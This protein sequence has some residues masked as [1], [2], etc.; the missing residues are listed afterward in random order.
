MARTTTPA[1]DGLRR[2][3]LLGAAAGTASALA[4][5]SGG[6]ARAVT[7][8]AEEICV[9]APT[10]PFDPASGRGR[11]E[12]REVPAAARCP[13]CGMF[14]A[15]QRRWAAQVIYRDGDAHFFD[16]PAD[17]HRFL[18]EVPRHARGRA[19]A[20][21][22]AVWLSDWRS[23]AWIALNDAWHVAASAQTGPMRTADLPSFANAA[24]A[25]DFARSHGGQVVAARQV[26][27]TQLRTLVPGPHR[28]AAGPA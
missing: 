19:R 3:L 22:S 4:R 28:H 15:R 23:G 26:D 11:F 13:V 24:A 20:D 5:D 25:A 1:C 17:L 21:V 14:P 6:R 12:A 27:A 18:A 7:L 2:A 16:A 8:P 10:W 9:S